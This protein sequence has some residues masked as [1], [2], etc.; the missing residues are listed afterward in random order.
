MNKIP[1]ATTG[2]FFGSFNPIHNG[3]LIIAQYMLDYTAIDEVWFVVSPHNPFKS[4]SGLLAGIKRLEMVQLAIHEN[5]KFMACDIELEL[6]T[7][8]YTIHT[9][10]ALQQKHPGQSFA[11]IMGTDNLDSLKKW[12]DYQRIA[13]QFAIYAY[14]RPGY[15]LS[16]IPDFPDTTIVKAPLMEISSSLIRK[17]IAEGKN[18]S[19]MMP[20]A[21]LEKIRLEKLYAFK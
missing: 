12:K 17:M 13:G 9:L 20:K 2:L 10:D 1:S 15:D 4:T 7:P 8:S 5:P 6:G 3:H 18:P 21:V 19:Y 16:R 11:L 14:P